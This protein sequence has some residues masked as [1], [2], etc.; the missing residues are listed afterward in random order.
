[1]T[2][3]EVGLVKSDITGTPPFIS[4]EPFLNRVSEKIEG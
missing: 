2:P 1:M 3:E 4:I